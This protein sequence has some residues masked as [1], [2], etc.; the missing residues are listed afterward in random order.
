VTQ[1]IAT[2]S[3]APQT[4]KLLRATPADA[5]ATFASYDGFWG[6]Y[7]VKPALME[8]WQGRQNRLHDR[9]LY[10]CQPGDSWTIEQLAP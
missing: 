7:R 1:L 4:C 8:F 5:Q 6:G 9:F 10:T 3:Q 2:A